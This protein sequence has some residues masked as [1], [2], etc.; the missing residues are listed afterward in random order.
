MPRGVE[1]EQFQ[2]QRF[3]VRA[4]CEVE[5]RRSVVCD[6]EAGSAIPGGHRADADGLAPPGVRIA[7]D[8]A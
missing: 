1:E 5:N 4:G 7:S 2:V 3:V 8:T 6:A